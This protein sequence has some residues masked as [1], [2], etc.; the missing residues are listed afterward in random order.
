MLFARTDLP[1][2]MLSSFNPHPP[3][4]A[5]AIRGL[6]QVKLPAL[7]S[8]LTRPYGRMLCGESPTQQGSRQGFNPHPPLRADAMSGLHVEEMMALVSILTRPYGRM[9]CQVCDQAGEHGDVS[10]LT[11]PY[12]RMLCGPGAI[13]CMLEEK[14]QSS[15]ALT[16]GCYS[17]SPKPLT[18][19]GFF[20]RFRDPLSGRSGICP[21][22]IKD[23]EKIVIIR[24]LTVNA[25]LPA[26][27]PSLQVRTCG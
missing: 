3:L 25:I 2:K 10:I 17:F 16:G 6:F 23:N 13:A 4:R 24:V 22:E 7:V 12:G 8:I 15:P 18:C 1:Y 5:D 9:L 19:L 20:P 21:R 11:R 27:A 26:V 14:F